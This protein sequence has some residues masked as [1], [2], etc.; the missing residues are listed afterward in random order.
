MVC[1]YNM[2]QTATDSFFCDHGNGKLA[3]FTTVRRSGEGFEQRGYANLQADTRI[4]KSVTEERGGEGSWQM[5]V[6]KHNDER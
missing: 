2:W 4:L 3:R 6:E 5:D 1:F